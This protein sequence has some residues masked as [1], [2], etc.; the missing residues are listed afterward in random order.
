MIVVPSL[1]RLAIVAIVAVGC[2]TGGQSNSSG[3]TDGGTCPTLQLT[4]QC[5]PCMT[6]SCNAESS[7]AL[8]PNWASHDF[9]GGA[10]A[11][12]IGCYCTCAEDRGCVDQC[13]RDRISA[14]CHDALQT[15]DTCTANA[16]GSSCSS[17]ALP[18][19]A[20]G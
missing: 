16:C 17:A 15:L 18:D 19:A 14:G 20:T 5:A 13:E 12:L 2:G 4:D 1:G 8:G 9:T 3:P 10:C 7:A 11:D 6:A